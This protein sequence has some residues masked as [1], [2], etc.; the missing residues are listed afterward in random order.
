MSGFNSRAKKGARHFSS[1]IHPE[2]LSQHR[3]TEDLNVHCS[4]TQIVICAESGLARLNNQAIV[5][6][7]N[8]V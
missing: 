2:G 1:D 8:N 7:C 5:F 4:L 3:F 6:I